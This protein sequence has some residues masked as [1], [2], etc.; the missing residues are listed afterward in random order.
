MCFF[1]SF[2]PATFWAVL[3][4]FILFSATRAEGR[5]RILGHA[6][7][8]WAFVIA[9]FILAGGAYVTAT[10]MCSMDTLLQC[11]RWGGA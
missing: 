1:F 7:S 5:V 10:G 4:Y 6:L 2:V 11:G 9:G 8:I 3:G